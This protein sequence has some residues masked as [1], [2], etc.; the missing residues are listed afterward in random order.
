L[1]NRFSK[2]EIL[3]GKISFEKLVK[4]GTSLYQF[5]FRMIY[6]IN[7]LISDTS[8]IPLSPIFPGKIGITVPKR[9]FKR[10]VDRN[11]LK[12]RI[13]ESYRKLKSEE[14]YPFLT[15]RNIQLEF[16]LIYT[17]HEIL[18]SDFM[19]NKLKS[20]IAKFKNGFK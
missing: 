17:H 20:L 3:R 4:Q 8:E 19:A 11:K 2:E 13:R 9:K 6:L 16:L 12:R 5:P 1:N 7:P 10:A 14:L 15:D 18:E